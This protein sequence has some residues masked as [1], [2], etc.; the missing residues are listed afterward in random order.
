MKKRNLRL[1]VFT[2]G[3]FV[4]VV[5]VLTSCGRDAIFF[6]IAHEVPP[7][8]PLIRGGPTQM[9]V[10][11]WPMLPE[12][13]AMAT[14]VVAGN[15]TENENG[16]VNGNYNGSGN[17]NGYVT[18]PDYG[19]EDE[20]APEP[21]PDNNIGYEVYR[22]GYRQV[23]FV[24]SGNNLFW[25]TAGYHIRNKADGS[26]TGRNAG[27]GKDIRIP[28]RPRGRIIDIAATQNYLYILVMEGTG[29]TTTIHRLVSGGDAWVPM[30]FSG[31]GN[32][33]SVFAD[34]WG[35]RLFAGVQSGGVNFIYTSEGT[36][37]LSRLGTE[38]RMVSD[39]PP[40]FTPNTGLLSGIA[41]RG[42]TYFLSTRNGILEVEVDVDGG[43]IATWLTGNDMT[44]AF[45]GIIKLPG[46]GDLQEDLGS[47]GTII[48]IA[49]AGGFLYEVNSGSPPARIQVTNAQGEPVTNAQG[50]PIWMG[51]GRDAT[52]AL[53]L[54]RERDG[55]QELLIAGIQG[56]RHATTFTNGY[57]E[58]R[59]NTDDRSLNTSAPR[60]EAGTT[61]DLFSVSDSAQYRTSL[62]RLPLNH[63][64]Q[65]PMEIDEYMTF[66]A[67]TQTAGL[68][69]YRTIDGRDQ[70][71]AEN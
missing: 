21:E 32:I 37:P 27:W 5:L 44:R 68:W 63:L 8:P 17:G 38:E 47:G 3:L 28:A 36:G 69:S 2:F 7:Q 31:P 39:D 22:P 18:E 54:W 56:S 52:G 24:A 62:G 23:L 65:T 46:P 61:N 59:L 9:V 12:P 57:V 35:D 55:T 4:A 1:P 19:G 11:N 45:M 60:M 26:I 14:E 71:N 29:I 10:F 41:F 13:A 40:V 15:G 67:S 48:A 25:Y 49:R 70:W 20:P 6:T 66:F 16:D 64:L 30:E 51:T 33:Q 50:D 42:G 43:E 34:P 53:A 58:F